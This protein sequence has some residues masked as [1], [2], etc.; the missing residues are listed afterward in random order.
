MEKEHV[1]S[2]EALDSIQSALA[3]NEHWLAYNTVPYF[4]GKEDVYAFRHKEEAEEFSANNISE[5][6]DYE[7]IHA[8]SMAEVF[9]QIPYGQKLEEKITISSPEKINIMNEKNYG[10]LKDQLKYTGFGDKLNEELKEKMNQTSD[11]TL[12]HAE[13][14]GNDSVSAVLHFKKSE[15]SDFFFFNKYQLSLVKDGNQEPLKQTFYLD[16]SITLKEGYNLL[17]GRAV[18]KTLT[19]KEDQ[20]YNAWLQLDFKNLNKSGNYEMKQYHQNY[21]Y[22]LEKVLGKY[23]IQE[24][25]NEKFKESLI[26]SLQRGNLQSATFLLDGQEKKLFITPN[27]SFKTITAYDSNMQ[28]LPLQSLGQKQEQKESAN[29]EQT[30]SNGQKPLQSEKQSA[31]KEKSLNKDEAKPERKQKNR[32]KIAH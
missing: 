24:L 21:G 30:L 12:M 17:D 23:P 2:D 16:K 18:H 15:Q 10:F 31:K 20:K 3:K 26:K 13:K 4:L 5:Y 22:D 6:D 11:F 28:R 1:I 9:R 7:V 29:Q 32:H 27:L 19:T 14:Y 25:N 8:G